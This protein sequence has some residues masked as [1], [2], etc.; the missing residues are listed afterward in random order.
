M[1][2]AL[3]TAVILSVSGCGNSREEPA[4]EP[5]EERTRV[6]GSITLD[7]NFTPRPGDTLATEGTGVLLLDLT[8]RPDTLF[9]AVTD[10]L[11]TFDG[12]AV[13]PGQGAYTIRLYRNERRLADSTLILAHQDTIR[14]EGSL[15]RFAGSA[16]FH[17]AENEAMRTLNRLERQYNR[18]IQIAA[19]GGI[20]QDTIPYVLDNWSSIF[21]EVWDAWPGTVAARI[22]ARESLRMLEDRNDELLL[23]RLRDYGDDEN[24]RMLAARFGFMSVLQNSG[25]DAAIAWADSLEAES[26][27]QETRLRIAKN[28]IE[29]L[30]DSSRIDQARSRIRDYEARFAGDQEADAWLSVMR[31][32]V[33]ELS[34]GMRL[35]GFELEVLLPERGDD[36]QPQTGFLTLEDLSGAPSLVEV[37]S[38]A[39]RLYQASYPQL[40]TLYLI[41]NQEDV[42][43]L[44]IPIEQSAIAVR[45]FYE[46]RGQDWPVARAGAFAE[47][48]LEEQWNI[49]EMPVR[50]LI[51]AEGRIIR[52]FHGHNINEIL[53]ELNRLINDG[54][55]S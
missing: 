32:D 21:W 48:D 54:E 3:L 11:G 50:F 46:E 38:L 17:S 7:D 27:S 1:G 49:Y 47:T 10:A 20:A 5:A 52:K 16:R 43:F 29:V 8:G 53:I 9:R 6:Y 13:F 39:D 14:I 37:V 26:T 44:S 18:V 36:D 35:P 28:R 40:Q 42:Q 24:I 34:P 55:I 4:S 33:E 25:L 41:F 22:A 51:N 23:Q 12:E 2:L 31:R 19:A 45:A 15:P 30:Y